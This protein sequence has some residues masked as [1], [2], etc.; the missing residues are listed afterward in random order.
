MRHGLFILWLC[1]AMAQAAPP[2]PQ[3]AVKTFA[4]Q[5]TLHIEPDA[6]SDTQAMLDDLAWEPTAFEVTCQPDANWGSDA[7]VQFDSPR[8]LGEPANDRVS[9]EWYAA[10]D[11]H[12]EVID[13]PAVL[14]IHESASSMS[15]GRLIASALSR[16]RVHTFMLQLPGYGLRKGALRDDPATFSPRMVQGIADARRARDAIAALPHVDVNRIGIQGTSL[17]G[18]VV[19][20]AAAMDDAFDLVCVSVS[21]GRLDVVLTQGQR[22]AA[23]ARTMLESTGL[24]WPDIL[25]VV[26][27]IEPT[28][29]AHRISPGK[30]YLFTAESDTVI[31][32]ASSDALAAAV[33]MEEDHHV[34]MPGDHYTA[35]INL[36]GMI[37]YVAELAYGQALPSP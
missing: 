24:A 14:V 8:P 2:Q 25:A 7:L 22:D 30:F 28:R 10:R 33:G 16:R 12:G 9:M 26:R 4:A 5:D 13:A 31:P 21:G 17:G 23:K 3:S 34:R 18:F 19:T 32:A 20:P 6:D 15:V 27:R 35:F 11:D 1:C 29:I 37:A 36:P